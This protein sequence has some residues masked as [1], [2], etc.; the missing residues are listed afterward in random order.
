M[1]QT[2]D[3][4]GMA[5]TPAC[6]LMSTQF[7]SSVKH[8]QQGFACLLA[9]LL[10]CGN[11]TASRPSSTGSPAASSPPSLTA[12]NLRGPRRWPGTSE[13]RGRQINIESSP[14]P[15]W[16]VGGV[17]DGRHQRDHHRGER[18]HVQTRRLEATF[19]INVIGAQ[20]NAAYVATAQ[21]TDGAGPMKTFGEANHNW[22]KLWELISQVDGLGREKALCMRVTIHYLEGEQ[23]LSVT[24]MKP[25]GVKMPLT[26][27]E[28]VEKYRALIV[29]MVGE[30]E[31]VAV[32]KTLVRP[33][34][35]NG[36]LATIPK[37]GRY[38]QAVG[39]GVADW[40]T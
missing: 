4:F 16:Q 18:A 5:C 15:A 11:Y 23:H 21:L 10:A 28:I 37:A 9:N 14:T 30:G 13:R 6:G 24:V 40:R 39:D 1:D 32:E 33:Y 25:R 20:T 38:V 3:V 31:R 26:N 17:P 19:P 29:Y 7:E 12:Q 27:E 36:A 35:I 8:M 34:N 22:P 2:V